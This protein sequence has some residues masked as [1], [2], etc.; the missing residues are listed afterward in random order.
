MDTPSHAWANGDLPVSAHQDPGVPAASSPPPPPSAT[1]LRPSPSTPPR[2]PCI[3]LSD[4]RRPMHAAAT[5]RPAAPS[6][7]LHHSPFHHSRRILSI[8]R[9]LAGL[10]FGDDGPRLLGRRCLPA[11]SIACSERQLPVPPSAAPDLPPSELCRRGLRPWLKT[12]Y[13]TKQRLE[14]IGGL[15]GVWQCDSMFQYPASP[16][17]SKGFKGYSEH[18]RTI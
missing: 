17:L 1:E 4:V 11:A 9:P 8:P 16:V 5:P 15:T 18:A 7:S 3:A 10:S 12:I 13:G 14:S 6:P 2:R